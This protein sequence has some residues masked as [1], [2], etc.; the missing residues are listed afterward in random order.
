MRTTNERLIWNDQELKPKLLELPRLR[1]AS[2]PERWWRTRNPYGFSMRDV[3]T[4]RDALLNGDVAVE[5]EWSRA[6]GGDAATA[7]G[8]AIKALQSHGLKHPLTDAVLSAV[9]CCAIEGDQAAKVVML[10]ALRRRA[11]IDRTCFGLRLS[12][13]HVQF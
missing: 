7:I 2:C 10:S 13:L 3:K 11:K 4:I 5:G 1:S 9:L 6:I 8:I 12:W